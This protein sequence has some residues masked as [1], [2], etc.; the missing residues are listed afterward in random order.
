MEVLL[1][2]SHAEFALAWADAPNR[3]QKSYGQRSWRQP[4]VN[5]PARLRRVSGRR[6]AAEAGLTEPNQLPLWLHNELWK[7]ALLFLLD[8]LD[9]AIAEQ[10]VRRVK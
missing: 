10:L 8:E 6:I 2:R 7:A 4:L 3:G 5:S 1:V 9:Q